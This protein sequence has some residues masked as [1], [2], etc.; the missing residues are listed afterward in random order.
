MLGKD[1]RKYEIIQWPTGLQ[2]NLRMSDGSGVASYFALANYKSA[3]QL[4]ETV[5]TFIDRHMKRTM[6]C[7]NQQKLLTT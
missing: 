2:V 5:N 6:K 1:F 3:D 4:F 7:L